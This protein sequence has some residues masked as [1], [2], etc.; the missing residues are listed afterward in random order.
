[1]RV[2]EQQRVPH[3]PPWNWS[4]VPQFGC[5]SGTAVP[6]RVFRATGR[7]AADTAGGASAICSW[8]GGD[9]MSTTAA[10]WGVG[11][12]AAGVGGIKFKITTLV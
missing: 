10:A 6:V 9:S 12:G 7:R 8:P 4:A 2:E 3:L 11:M 5:W 1:M